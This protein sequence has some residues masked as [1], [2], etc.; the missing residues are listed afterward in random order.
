MAKPALGSDAA[1]AMDGLRRLVRGLRLGDAR[2]RRAAGISSAQL[3]ALR[4]ISRRSGQSLSDL[5]ASTLTAQ[6]SISEV[7]ARLIDGDFVAR[8]AADD[9]HRRTQLEL[10]AKGQAILSNSPQTPQEQLL[11]A[12]QSL[13]PRTQQLLAD[14]IEEWLK[15]A[16][17]ADAEPKMFFE[18]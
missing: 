2:I 6:S 9:D 5:A 18:S 12:L 16:E 17:L 8:N 10:T 3:F 14:S 1:R 15:S 13:A 7:V 11:A 4:Q